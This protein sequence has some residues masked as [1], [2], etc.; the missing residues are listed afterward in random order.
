MPLDIFRKSEYIAA[1]PPVM[2]T[3]RD[4]HDTLVRAAMDAAASGDFF[5]GRERYAADGRSRV[6]LAPR[7]WRQVA[8]RFPRGDGGNKRRFTG[9]S[10]KDTVKTIRAGKAGRDWLNLW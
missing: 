2:G 7:P 6:V 8:R 10:T 9:E 1:I 5:A 3:Y 4:R